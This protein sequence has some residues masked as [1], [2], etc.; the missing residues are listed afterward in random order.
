MAASGAIWV[1]PTSGK[2]AG[3]KIVLTK[4]QLAK[5][6]SDVGQDPAAVVKGIQGVFASDMAGAKDFLSDKLAGYYEPAKA[7][8]ASASATP[9]PTS[10]DVTPKEGLLWTNKKGSLTLSSGNV[11][12]AT[13]EG[14][15][16]VYKSAESGQWVVAHGATGVSTGATFKTQAEAL[17]AMHKMNELADWGFQDMKSVSPEGI[18]ALKKAVAEGNM[19]AVSLHL[20]KKAAAAE[21]KYNA[22]QAAAEVAKKAATDIDQA[23]ADANAL[24]KKI[25]TPTAGVTPAQSTITFGSTT[26]E[27]QSA[28]G[29]AVHASSPAGSNNGQ[30]PYALTIE[31]TKKTVGH[32]A[33]EQD[34]VQALQ[35][36]AQDKVWGAKIASGKV[37]ADEAQE[38]HDL[39]YQIKNGT[40]SATAST[41]ALKIKKE[42]AKGAYDNAAPDWT[43]QHSHWHS[44]HEAES[45]LKSAFA[46]AG[47]GPDLNKTQLSAVSAW[48]D[49]KFGAINQTLWGG[50]T[51]SPGSSVDKYI[52]NLDAAFANPKSVAPTSFIAVRHT[53][54]HHTLS[55]LNVGDVYTAKGYD[56]AANY[57]KGEGY[58]V[59]LVYRV[60]A[61]V[62]MIHLNT[63]PGYHSQY[64]GE[65]EVLFARNLN[66][67]VVGK[68]V[69]KGGKVVLT[70]EYAGKV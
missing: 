69:S 8:K 26:L 13:T 55:S 59:A 46:A 31:G 65:H 18:A 7:K 20:E 66:W 24:G 10:Y 58:G 5:W 56:A 48:Q 21:K 2:Y 27:A 61:G 25:T 64:T 45:G 23:I 1:K 11:V 43:A 52:K 50:Q 57:N 33:T 68:K 39:I 70:L 28:G 19:A 67:N 60:P 62:P 15:L 34:A 63:L 12:K 36:L 41:E 49:G 6:A 35:T 44:G 37:S 51:P 40:Y 38:I 22:Q 14:G 53:S 3:Q 47:G 4:E 16:A 54:H 17:V 29:M 32:F 42:L 30:T 9:A